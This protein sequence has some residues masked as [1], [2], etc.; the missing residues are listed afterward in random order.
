[1]PN[2]TIVE[3]TTSYL[4]EIQEQLFMGHHL[5]HHQ[6]RCFAQGV[7]TGGYTDSQLGAALMALKHK[8]ITAEE[9]TALAQIMQE[10][11]IAIPYQGDAMDN[12]GTGGDHSNSFNISTTTAFVL[13]AGGITMAKHG[14]RSVSS[15]SG[16]AD[17]LASLGINI[18][19]TPT[20]IADMLSSIGIAFLFAPSLHPGMKAVMKVRQELATPTIFNLLGPL[21]NPVPLT[22]QLMGTYAGETLEDTAHSLGALGRKRGMVIH[23]Y[24]GMDEANLAGSVQI[25]RFQGQQVEN[26]VLDPKEYGFASAPIQ[27]IIGGDAARNATILTDVLQNKPSLYLETVVL[28]AGLGFC[29]HG[30]VDTFSEGFALAR[31]C[32]ASGAAFDKLQALI[33]ASNQHTAS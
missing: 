28:N 33:T 23:G 29:A 13:A 31:A 17:V 24:Q 12:C 25:S 19:S 1:M 16:S 27:A 22:T 26:I 8:G 7:L 15:R 14:N 4:K 9:L 32:I 2:S 30:S 3:N 11:A 20:H 5:T 6:M 18:Q 21:I 10:Q